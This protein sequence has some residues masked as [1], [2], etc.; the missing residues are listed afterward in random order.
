MALDLEQSAAK[1]IG[2]SRRFSLINSRV[3]GMGPSAQIASRSPQRSLDRLASVRAQIPEIDTAVF[4]VDTSAKIPDMADLRSPEHRTIRND[5]LMRVPNHKPPAKK[6]DYDPVNRSTVPFTKEDEG[7][8]GNLPLIN[9][10]REP[11][12]FTKVPQSTVCNPPRFY[13]DDQAKW[14]KKF[15]TS[16]KERKEFKRSKMARAHFNCLNSNTNLNDAFDWDAKL[17]GTAYTGGQLIPAKSEFKQV[18]KR[19]KSRQSTRM[20]TTVDFD[21]LG[22]DAGQMSHLIGKSDRGQLNFD[23]NLRR[24]K[25]TTECRHEAPFQ[26]PSVKSFA[27][28]VALKECVELAT[29][30]NHNFAKKSFV[31]KFDEKNANAILHL[32]EPHGTTGKY[33]QHA[34]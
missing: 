24:Y 32:L 27:P 34:W 16:I 25:Q 12:R 14:A 7:Q 17:E 28:A 5:S 29:G 18:L 13:E 31:D 3:G 9:T 2:H 4:R 33:E 21:Y 22:G 1:G 8:F 23:L 30:T 26:Y 11:I 19:R 6:Y 15:E 10:L 20:P